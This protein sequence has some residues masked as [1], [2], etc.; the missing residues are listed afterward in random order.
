MTVPALTTS[1]LLGEDVRASRSRSARRS[2]RKSCAAK[3]RSS[4]SVAGPV[5]P[6]SA[7]AEANQPSAPPARL[8]ST[9]PPVVSVPIDRGR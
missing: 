9:R 5:G 4:W 6:D 2:P 7:S 3:T 8:R 1:E